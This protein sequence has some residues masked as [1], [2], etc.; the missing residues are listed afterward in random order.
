MRRRQLS[1]CLLV[2][3][4]FANLTP[5]LAG[6]APIT[7]RVFT[8]RLIAEPETLDWNRAHTT[9]ENYILTNIMEGLVT[10]NSKMEI[11]PA[12][13]ES[14][15]RSKNGL[16][17][18]FRLRKDAKWT[19]GVPLKAEDFVYSWRRLLDPKT[20]ASILFAFDISGAEGFNRGTSTNHRA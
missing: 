4:L 16:T 3:I 9:V 7:S 5:R 2:L 13:A 15:I 1:W 19:D 8:F 17:Y 14:W 10:Y 12:L 18:T 6:A 11:T 20:A